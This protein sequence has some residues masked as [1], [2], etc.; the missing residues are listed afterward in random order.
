M[1]PIR[2]GADSNSP[3]SS[4]AGLP[5]RLRRRSQY[6]SA[7]SEIAPSAISAPTASP[8]SCQ[9][10]MPSTTPPIPTT[11]SSEPTTSTLRSPV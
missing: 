11:D 1:I 3:A 8:P 6:A 5:S 9:T 2:N 7:A 4:S 10:R